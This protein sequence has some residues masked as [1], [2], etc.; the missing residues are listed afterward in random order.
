MEEELLTKKEKIRIKKALKERKRDEAKR[1]RK[2]TLT[3]LCSAVLCVIAAA[4]LFGVIYS[5]TK[6]KNSPKIVIEP[7]E[8]DAGT[9][10]LADK[11]LE[12]IFEVKNTGSDDLKINKIWTSCMCTVATLKVEGKESEEFT[13]QASELSS[14]I[15]ISQGQL[16]QLKMVFNQNF[17]GPSGVGHLTRSVYISS[18]DP[19]LEKAEARLNVNVVK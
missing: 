6:S 16:G 2:I 11:N 19:S 8:F 9:V 1:K 15:I 12:K 7:A 18:N 4:V 13:M 5:I 17:H 10:S 14:P 3:I